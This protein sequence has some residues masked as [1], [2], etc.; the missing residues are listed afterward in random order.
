MLSKTIIIITV[1][2]KVRLL[3]LF[4]SHTVFISWT[5]LE[6]QSFRLER[7]QYSTPCKQK[8][9]FLSLIVDYRVV[10]HRRHLVTIANLRWQCDQKTASNICNYNRYDDV[11]WSPTIFVVVFFY[12]H[13]CDFIPHLLLCDRHYAE[14]SGYFEG[15]PEFLKEAK[16]ASGPME[17]TAPIGRSMDD[18]LVESRAHGWPRYDR[19]L[20]I[21]QLLLAFSRL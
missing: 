6:C 9:H 17:F 20:L 10:Y 19:L 21:I 13:Q 8:S 18:F 5:V 1:L 7:V 4:H 3:D 11:Q 15:K 2:F 14:H 16:V 12:S